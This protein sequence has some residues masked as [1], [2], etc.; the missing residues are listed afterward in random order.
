M[1]MAN[2]TCPAPSNINPLSPTGFML[3]IQKLPEVA[4]FSQE[5]T[6]PSVDL[7]HVDVNTPLSRMSITGEVL[8]Y[9]DFTINFLVDEEMQNYNAVYNW[10]K[11]LGFP[12]DHNEYTSYIERQKSNQN[13]YSNSENVASYSDASLSILG[14]SNTPIKTFKFID[15]HPVSLSS[16][17]FTA[18]ATDVN[19]LI[20]SASFR[21]TYFEIE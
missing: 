18:N 13:M 21:Y 6:L 15:L 17:Q 11:G 16:L 4:F 14:S 1:I 10:L 2:L 12:K 5:V 3:S 20:G 9:G 8:T 7:P 19:Y